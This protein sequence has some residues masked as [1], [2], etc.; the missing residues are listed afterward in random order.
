MTLQFNDIFYKWVPLYVRL[1]VLFVIF[2][3][4]LVS[5]GIFLG[6]VTFMYSGLGVDNESITIASNSMYVGMGLGLMTHLRI[7]LRFSN[8]SLLLAGLFAMLALNLVCATTASPGVALL[9]SLL[10][11]FS[12]VSALIEVYVIWLMVWSKKADTSRLYPFVYFTALSGVYLITW[13]TTLLTIHFNWRFSAVVIIILLLV[14]LLFAILFVENHPLEKKLPL[15]RVDWPG[16][17][18]LAAS[19]TL[20]NYF[21]VYGEVED[22]FNSCKIVAAGFAFLICFLWFIRRQMT[23]KHPLLDLAMFRSENLRKGLVYFFLL[24]I[25]IPSNAQSVLVSGVLRLEV[26]RSTELNLYAIPGIFI[27]AALSYWWY[28][29][30]HVPQLLMLTGFG[31]FIVHHFLLYQL[32]SASLNLTHFWLPM[33]IKGFALGVLYISMGLYTVAGF[34]IE[35]VLTAAGMVIIV[36]SFL[37][38][39]IFAALYG[40]WLHTQRVRH[41]DYLT[42]HADSGDFLT[43]QSGSLANYYQQMQEQASLA[44]AKELTGYI[45]IAGVLLF[46]LLTA[47]FIHR[48]MRDSQVK[49]AG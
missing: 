37:G 7:K 43:R 6:N 2:F 31:A 15:Y 14:C 38:S 46:V 11:G 5:N 34:K 25:F 20:I 48:T 10:L 18:L 36:R 40:Y 45:V 32:F 30:K 16:L 22:W 28:V 24:G 3:A 39:D 1:P 47:R 12:K 33:L 8:K 17:L 35:K 27:G 42:G 13:L 29:K 21:F 23:I 41:F 49:I 44:A 26:I 9:A 19:A 4:T